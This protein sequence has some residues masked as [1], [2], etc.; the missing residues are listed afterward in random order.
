MASGKP[1]SDGRPVG[2]ARPRRARVVGAVD[3]AVELHEDPLRARR[4]AL[5]PV[6]AQRDLVRR[7]V[8]GHVVRDQ[9]VVAA[10]PARAAVVGQPDPGGGDRHRQPLGLPG[11]RD[12]RVQAEAAGAGLP[13]RPRRMLEE[14]PV[15]RERRAPVAALEQDAGVAARVDDAVGLAGLDHPDPLERR[16]AAARELQPRGLLPLAALVEVVDLGP[17]E[18]RRDRREHAPRARIA[19][20]ELDRLAGE[21][22]AGHLE[23]AARGSREHEQALLGPQQQLGHRPPPDSAGSTST[24]SSGST[25]VSQLHS[26]P[27]TNTLM[28]RRSAPR[29]SRIQPLVAGCSRS[30]ARSSS[31]TECPS[32]GMLGAVAGQLLQR[33]AEAH[34]CHARILLA[35]VCGPRRE[36]RPLREA[37]PPDGQQGMRAIRGRRS[38]DRRPRVRSAACPGT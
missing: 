38:C 28:W 12:D 24:R 32:I 3:A 34:D 30:S 25:A 35:D 11:P 13:A 26:S 22:A 37:S 7:R 6:H 5:E 10:L 15:E 17:V 23:P 18:R 27:L 21:R 4:G 29:S 16:V 31:P 14:R 33:T 9:A 20:R 2:D 8:V 19:H 1:K 36:R